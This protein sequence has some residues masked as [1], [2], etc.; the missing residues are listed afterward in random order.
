MLGIEDGGNIGEVGG[1]DML[2]I[3]D[4]GNIGEVGGGG[5][6]WVLGTGAILGR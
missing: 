6:C 5:I 3:G 4:G 2:G 1:G